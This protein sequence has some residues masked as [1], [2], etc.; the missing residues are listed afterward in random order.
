MI[1]LYHIVSYIFEIENKIESFYKF[2]YYVEIL[3]LALGYV[4]KLSKEHITQN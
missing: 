2:I 1:S 3:T 4:I